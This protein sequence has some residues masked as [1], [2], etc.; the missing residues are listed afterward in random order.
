MD[1]ISEKA[2]V[3]SSRQQNSRLQCGSRSVDR[4]SLPNQFDR[5]GTELH[6]VNSCPGVTEPGSHA[7]GRGYASSPW[8]LTTRARG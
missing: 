1:P 7:S 8:S 2:H 3:A 4:A 6:A 5:T